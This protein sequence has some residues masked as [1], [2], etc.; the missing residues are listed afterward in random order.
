MRDRKLI[1][2][3]VKESNYGGDESENNGKNWWERKER[4][5]MKKY[6]IK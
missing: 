3:N 6:E 1:E 5:I 4:K 2:R